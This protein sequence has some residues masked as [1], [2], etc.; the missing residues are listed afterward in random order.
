M[1]P[2]F[3]KIDVEGHEVGCIRGATDL[4]QRCHPALMIEVSHPEIF[5]LLEAMGY[6]VHLYDQGRFRRWDGESRHTNYFFLP[7]STGMPTG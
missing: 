5:P 7:E 6:G 2:A 1:R 4:L 3:L